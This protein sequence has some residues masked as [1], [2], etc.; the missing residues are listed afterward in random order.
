MGAGEN[1]VVVEHVG[2]SVIVD[3]GRQI[4]YKY[5]EIH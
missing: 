1:K 3:S 4:Y 5:I 2:K